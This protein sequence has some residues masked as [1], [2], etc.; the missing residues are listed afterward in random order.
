LPGSIK[1]AAKTHTM[2]ELVKDAETTARGWHTGVI[3]QDAIEQPHTHCKTCGDAI[4]FG[5]AITRSRA[6]WVA[7]SEAGHGGGG[8]AVME[9]HDCSK[10]GHRAAPQQ[11]PQ[12]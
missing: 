5:K 8:F 1:S 9:K 7:Y 6:F 11:Q 10:P 4:W 3:P 12:P 2:P